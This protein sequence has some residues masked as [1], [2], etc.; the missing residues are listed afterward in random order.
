VAEKKFAEKLQEVTRSARE[1]AKK[2]LLSAQD[3]VSNGY[4]MARNYAAQ[5]YGAAKEYATKGYAVA[6]DYADKGYRS[7]REYTKAGADFAA[8]TSGDLDEL[9]RDQPWI[10]L[11][12]A[13]AVG[14]AAARIVRSFRLRPA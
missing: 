8:R 14:Y 4:R 12:A 7:G 1:T 10:A 2:G 3:T 13:F 6:K 5:G 11:V 9:V